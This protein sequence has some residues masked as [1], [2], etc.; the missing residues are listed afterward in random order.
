M[1]TYPAV[2]FK[3][4]SIKRR[5]KPSVD[6]SETGIVR[7]QDLSAVAVYDIEIEHPFITA[8]QVNTLQSFYDSN[9]FLEITTQALSD[10]ATYTCLMVDEPE[11]KDLNGIYKHVTQ[12][13]VGTRD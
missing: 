1:A 11:I 10:G 7:A 2:D 6:I 4:K 9:K 12:R 3:T 5:N 13:L 8:S